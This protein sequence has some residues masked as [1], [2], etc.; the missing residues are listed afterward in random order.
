M[1][2]RW[3]ADVCMVASGLYGALGCASGEVPDAPRRN[4]P[5]SAFSNQVQPEVQAPPPAPVVGGEKP[6][7]DVIDRAPEPIDPCPAAPAAPSDALTVAAALEDFTA[8][9]AAGS[10]QTLYISLAH[11]GD[12]Q[13]ECGLDGFRYGVGKLMNMMS[14]A[15]EIV[16]PAYVDEHKYLARV[17]LGDL[18]WTPESLAYLLAISDHV[19]DGVL[20]AEAP[21]VVR[22]DWLAAYLTRPPAY[23]YIMHNEV[24]ERLIEAQMGVDAAQPGRLAGVSES[25]VTLHPRILERRASADGACWIS[26]DFLHRPQALAV[27]EQGMLPQGDLRFALQQYIARE[28]ICTLPNGMHSYHLTG[29]VSQRRWDGNTCVARNRAREDNLVLAG[30]CFS[31]HTNGLIQ[32]EDEVRANRQNPS[33]FI[34]DNYATQDELEALFRSDQAR[35]EAAVS[36]IPYYAADVEGPVNRLIAAYADR[37]GDPLRES[38][39]GAFGAV[40][41]GGATAGPFWEDVVNPLATLAVDLGVLLPA[42]LIF[43]DLVEQ[44]VPGIEQR[45]RDVGLDPDMNCE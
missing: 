31:C 5:A 45:Y 10:A 37:T 32:F 9:G 15:D 23:V 11:L 39:A 8:L 30:Q 19:D 29:F 38:P 3:W 22:A 16:A 34:L 20:R 18:G 13:T 17:D 42:E 4:E 24:T 44:V 26:H 41:P 43:E 28:Y 12:G 14:W 7:P 27:F 25:I 1:K 40:L 36:Q 33:Q 21:T 35:F 6:D 2:R